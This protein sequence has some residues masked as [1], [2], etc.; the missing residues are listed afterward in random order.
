MKTLAAIVVLS[1]C[2]ALSTVSIAAE[3][4]VTAR[5]FNAARE[6][7]YKLFFLYR[8]EFGVDMRLSAILKACEFHQLAKQ[9]EAQ[10]PSVRDF[11]AKQFALNTE[12]ANYDAS[13]ADMLFYVLL[14]SESLAEAYMFGYSEA[15]KG[16]LQKS[17]G[18]TAV[19]K[20]YE[21]RLREKRQSAN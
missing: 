1:L 14:V 12:E 8:K 19:P 13:P 20:V 4:R 10:S 2:S 7:G 18:C 9:L 11:A 15:M 16:E 21:L 6:H 3:A 5:D 17:N